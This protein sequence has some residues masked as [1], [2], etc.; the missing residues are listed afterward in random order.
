MSVEKSLIKIK[1]GSEKSFG[2]L[3]AIVFAVFGLYSVYSQGEVRLWS[4]A[5]SAAFL[6]VTLLRPSLLA[7]PNYWWFRF[8]LFLGSIIAPIVMALVYIV[9]IVPLGLVL[10]ALGKDLLM[11][12]LDKN[13]KSY[14]IDRETPLQPM[15]NQF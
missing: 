2:Y 5:I 8:G 4:L 7:K 10:R 9:T 6:L 3:F 14:W 13:A 15:K 1:P 11:I 12:K